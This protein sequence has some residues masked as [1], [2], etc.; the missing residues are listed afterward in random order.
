VIEPDFT[1]VGFDAI[2]PCRDIE[3]FPGGCV[4][5][6]DDFYSGYELLFRDLIIDALR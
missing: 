5:A 4:T 6:D 1:T 3:R 2:P